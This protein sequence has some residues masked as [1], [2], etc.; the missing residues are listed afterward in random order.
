MRMKLILTVIGSLLVVS[1]KGGVLHP[2]LA[3]ER[4]TIALA[5]QNLLTTPVWLAKE[6][7]FFLKHGLEVE[8]VYIPSGTVAVQALLGGDIKAV[9]AAGSAV[10]NANLRGAPIKII[11][12]N[13][14]YYPNDFFSTPEIGGPLDLRGKRV[15]LTRVGSGAHLA[16]VVLLRKFGLEEGTDYTFLQLGSTQ[17]RLVALIK[18]IIQGTT[19]SAPESIMARNAG[20]KV[21]ISGSD[22]KRVGVVIQ[23]MAV[24]TT[25][26]LLRESRLVMKAFLMGYLNGVREVYRDKEATMR[27]LGKYTRITDSQVLSASYDESYEAID[28]EGNL[29][30][31]AVQVILKELGKSDPKA[32]SARPGQFFEP[33]LQQEL[34]TEGFIKTLWSASK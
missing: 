17:N 18:G 20:M 9:L 26:R 27:V 4:F 13:T 7:G 33:S 23:H 28:R 15:G 25:D 24:V 6:K 22:M 19:L 31:E 12:G 16:T 30:E 34:S 8:S 1:L 3:A 32:R 21:L 10:V 11:A 5:A 29:V 14:N 2:L